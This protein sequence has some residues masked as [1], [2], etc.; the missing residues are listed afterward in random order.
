MLYSRIGGQPCVLTSDNDQCDAQ[1][2]DVVPSD[3]HAGGKG[4]IVSCG[5]ELQA[6]NFSFDSIL[7]RPQRST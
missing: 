5:G 4:S 1:A 3:V 2:A 6:S 7:A